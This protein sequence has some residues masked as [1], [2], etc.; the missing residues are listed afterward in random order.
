MSWKIISVFQEDFGNPP[1][2]INSLSG[3]DKSTVEERKQWIDESHAKGTHHSWYCGLNSCPTVAISHETDHSLCR[4]EFCPVIKSLHSQLQHGA[5]SAHWCEDKRW[6]DREHQRG[7][8]DETR[9]FADPMSCKDVYESHITDHKLCRPVFCDLVRNLHNGYDDAGK[10]NREENHILCNEYWCSHI[11]DIKNKERIQK[12]HDTGDHSKCNPQIDFSSS[13]SVIKAQH[14]SGNHDLCNGFYCKDKS[15]LDAHQRGY[16]SE[17]CFGEKCPTYW[18]EH[19]KE[20][21]SQ[22]LHDINYCSPDTC[23][24]IK[25]SHE[26]NHYL[27]FPQAAWC[28]YAVRA[29]TLLKWLQLDVDEE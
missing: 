5:C 19:I 14:S 9:C 18:A 15:I 6:M 16:H 1:S 23:S 11:K 4:P 20:L 8:H 25:K 27:C 13:C 28:S 3:G 12:L 2:L 29:Q 22:K 10:R 7:L 21:H 26:T 17:Y 24:D